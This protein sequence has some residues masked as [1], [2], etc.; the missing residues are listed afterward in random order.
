MG[1]R[2]GRVRRGADEK[3]AG[4]FMYLVHVLRDIASG[5]LTAANVD[6]IEKLPQGLRTTTSA[7]GRKCAAPTT[8]SSALR[9][10]RRLP[11][12]DRA[13]AR[14]PRAT[15]S[16]GRGSSGAAGLG[17]ERARSD[18]SQGRADRVAR[19]PRRGGQRRDAATASTTPASRTSSPTRSARSPTTRRSAK[20]RSRRSLALASDAP[21]PSLTRAERPDSSGAAVSYSPCRWLTPG[22]RQ[23]RPVGFLGRSV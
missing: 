19:V 11:A 12:R 8:S 4:N 14:Q 6:D 18:G 5:A 2:R 21:V 16:S 15:R 13:R 22:S 9:A 20:Q 1:R 10:A 7:T 3:S 17:C 23:G